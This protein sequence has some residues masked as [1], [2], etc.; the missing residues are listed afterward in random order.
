MCGTAGVLAGVSKAF[1]SLPAMF[2]PS[3]SMTTQR[4][5][6]TFADGMM[7]LAAIPILV[8]PASPPSSGSLDYGSPDSVCPD[9]GEGL[10]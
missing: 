10:H 2:R 4:I 3:R 6:Q 1:S 7:L 5:S 8:L 9:I